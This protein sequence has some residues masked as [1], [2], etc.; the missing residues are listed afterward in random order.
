M[1]QYISRMNLFDPVVWPHNA[2]THSHGLIEIINVSKK[3]TKSHK[4]EMA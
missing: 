1:E 4:F 2:H 3:L